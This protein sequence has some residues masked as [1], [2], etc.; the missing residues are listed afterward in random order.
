M[1][2]LTSIRYYCHLDYR[3]LEGFCRN[4]S[5]IL[6]I[7]AP[8]HSTIYKRF[9]KM[10]F[11]PPS[12]NSEEIVIAVDF[13]GVKAHNSGDWMREKY[14]RRRRWLKIHFAVDVETKQIVAYG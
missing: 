14:R 13:T 2:F 8:D 9:L 12:L 10:D 6:G 11:N 1:Q 7:P 4:L 5:R 3:T